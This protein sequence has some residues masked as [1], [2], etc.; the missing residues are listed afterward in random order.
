MRKQEAQMGLISLVQFQVLAPLNVAK[1]A[2]TVH[3]SNHITRTA[4][5]YSK[6]LV[7][8]SSLLPFS[9]FLWIR[10]CVKFVYFFLNLARFS[11]PS[12]GKCK[13]TRNLLASNIPWKIK[14]QK[15]K[16]QWTNKVQ[17]YFHT[18]FL[19]PNFPPLQ[20]HFFSPTPHML[21]RHTQTSAT[22]P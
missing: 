7:V 8:V 13:Q 16:K 5:L 20:S 2:T 9:A 14:K 19:F 22:W 15:G 10:W 11:Q 18:V 3:H 6:G 17:P 4:C 1:L 21:H 12:A